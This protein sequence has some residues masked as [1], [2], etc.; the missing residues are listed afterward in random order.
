M[1]VMYRIVSTQRTTEVGRPSIPCSETGRMRTLVENFVATASTRRVVRGTNILP[2][3]RATFI[4]AHTV[5]FFVYLYS[6]TISFDSYRA[7]L[8]IHDTSLRGRLI[9]Y[10]LRL[11]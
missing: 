10:Q 9:E 11:G 3:W 5:I 8:C 7:M 6:S 2:P 4:S 1:P